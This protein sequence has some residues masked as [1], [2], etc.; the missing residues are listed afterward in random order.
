MEALSPPEIMR[1][2]SIREN[3]LRAQDSLGRATAGRSGFR[4]LRLPITC[5]A[6]GIAVLYCSERSIASL[7]DSSSDT[8]SAFA[9][10]EAFAS[11]TIQKVWSAVASVNGDPGQKAPANADVSRPQLATAASTTPYSSALASSSKR[12]SQPKAG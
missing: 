4:G 5:I 9:V 8:T 7:F 3:G 12:S 6:V 2:N 10:A 11:T 1:K